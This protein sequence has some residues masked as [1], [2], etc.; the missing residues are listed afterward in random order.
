MVFFYVEWKQQL[1]CRAGTGARHPQL[2]RLRFSLAEMLEPAFVDNHS[3]QGRC[4]EGYNYKNK[5]CIHEAGTQ[6]MIIARGKRSKGNILFAI[7]YVDMGILKEA[8]TAYVKERHNPV[9]SSI[10]VSL[11]GQFVVT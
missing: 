11:T 8:L 7:K 6:R 3:I 9:P 5:A 4:R 2:R 1:P 10:K